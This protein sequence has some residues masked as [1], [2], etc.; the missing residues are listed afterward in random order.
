MLEFIE[1]FVTF[2]QIQQNPKNKQQQL[3]QQRKT[4]QKQIKDKHF[5]Y[6]YMQPLVF[7]L[8][9]IYKEG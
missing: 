4:K 9:C 5:N 1:V 7:I 6:V 8:H 3:Q 2:W